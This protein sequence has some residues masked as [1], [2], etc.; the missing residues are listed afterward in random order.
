[1]LFNTGIFHESVRMKIETNPFTK[2]VWFFWQP[3]PN[4][5]ALFALLMLSLK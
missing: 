1:M 4:A 2:I 3:L 5:L